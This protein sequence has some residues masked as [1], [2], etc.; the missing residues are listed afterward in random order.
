M[1][2]VH[3]SGQAQLFYAGEAWSLPC[4]CPNP[5]GTLFLFKSS[6]VKDPVVPKPWTEGPW[7]KLE[8]LQVVCNSIC[9]PKY[10]YYQLL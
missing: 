10:Q 6:S 9:T 3:N 4:P 2:I 8:F 5:S 1:K 7:G